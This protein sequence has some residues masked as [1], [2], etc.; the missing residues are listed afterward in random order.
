MTLKELENRVKVKKSSPIGYVD[1]EITYRNKQYRCF[2][3]S[4]GW[5]TFATKKQKLEAYYD[6]CK[7][8]NHIG[9]YKKEE[10]FNQID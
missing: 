7:C 6:Y 5:L 3:Y 9:E 8:Q 2:M 1:V 10:K 4:L